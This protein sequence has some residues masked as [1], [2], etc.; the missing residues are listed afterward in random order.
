[1][2]EMALTAGICKTATE[3][4]AFIGKRENVGLGDMGQGVDHNYLYNKYLYFFND[5]FMVALKSSII[6]FF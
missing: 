2:S 1:M 5:H 3:E 6:K 4:P